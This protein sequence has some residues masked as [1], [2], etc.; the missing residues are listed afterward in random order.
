MSDD[1]LE[2]KEVD[3]LI[4]ELS[5]PPRK[6]AAAQ[7][8]VT[9]GPLDGKGVRA[10]SSPGT[11]KTFISAINLPPLPSVVTPPRTNRFALPALSRLAALNLPRLGRMPRFDTMRGFTAPRTVTVVRMCVALGV[12]LALAMPYWPYPKACTWW[13]FLYMCAVAMVLIAGVWA[14]RMTWATRLGVAHIVALC[15]IGWGIT[16]ATGA[17]G[18]MGTTAAR[19]SLER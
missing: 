13:L 17:T 16:G 10:V 12:L 3:L 9:T 8:A 11:V 2:R 5:S 19:G 7:A 4:N 6:P 1:N 18:R 14:A 15:V